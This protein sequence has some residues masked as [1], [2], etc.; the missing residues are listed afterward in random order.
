MLGGAWMGC[1]KLLPFPPNWSSD[2]GGG[3]YTLKTEVLSPFVHFRGKSSTFCTSVFRVLAYAPQGA[4]QLDRSF[5]AKSRNSN[6]MHG[7]RSR[8]LRYRFFALQNARTGTEFFYTGYS[9]YI[10]SERNS[11]VMLTITMTLYTLSYL[12]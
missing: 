2:M 3:A 5:P 8:I 4:C 1:C 7:L 11:F 6:D 12:K 10:F 9:F